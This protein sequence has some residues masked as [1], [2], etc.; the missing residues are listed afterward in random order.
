MNRRTM[1]IGAGAAAL[2]LFLWYFLLWSPRNDDLQDAKDR[3]E[4]AEQQRTQLQSEIARLRAAQKDEPLLRAQLETLRTSIPDDPNL[5]QFILDSNDAAI[6]SGIDFISIAPA[7]PAAPT[8]TAPA[9]PATPGAPGSPVVAGTPPAD[10]KLSLQI[11]G[12]YFQVLDFL[13]RLDALPRLVVTDGLSITSEPAASPR[14]TVS[15]TARMFV[16]ALPA[17]FGG[18]AAATTTTTT[19]PPA[20]GGTTTTTTTT[21]ASS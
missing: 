13:N 9:P 18:S 3:R 17:S 12:G 10:I 6:R 1:A 4:V 16:R 15:V 7:L 5:A 20:G 21:G 8:A 11:K 19:A 2:I 14:L